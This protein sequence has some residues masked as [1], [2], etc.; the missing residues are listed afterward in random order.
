MAKLGREMAVPGDTLL[1]DER[2]AD[3]FAEWARDAEPRLR[4]AMTAS[5]G[6]QLGQEAAADALVYAW[7]HWDRVSGKD[8]PFGYVFVVCRNKARGMTFWRRPVFLDVEEYHPPQV[9][10]GVAA[11][12][13]R[14]TE[15]QRIVVMLVYGYEWS[16]SEVAE[17]LGTKKTTVQKHA[18][19]GLA[20]LRESLGVEL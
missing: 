7:E 5:L 6:S 4:Q 20:R 14:L 10:P 15:K 17:L 8:N 18:E 19:R 2:V 12:I 11:A 13:A 3:S 9:E 1:L 16:M